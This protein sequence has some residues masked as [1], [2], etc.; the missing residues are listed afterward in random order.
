MLSGVR[1]PLV[2][3]PELAVI[4]KNLADRGLLARTVACLGIKMPYLTC[5][6]ESLV[7]I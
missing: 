6:E 5:P 2:V 3:F 1:F 7:E 4:T